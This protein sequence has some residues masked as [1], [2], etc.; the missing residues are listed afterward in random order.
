MPSFYIY[1]IS[2]LPMLH[3]GIKPPF[4]LARFI[5][6]CKDKIPDADIEVIKLIAEDNVYKGPQATLKQWA[7]FDIAL[8]NELVKIRASR[9][10]LD[11]LKYIRGEEYTEPYI[12]HLA[13]NAYRA[14]SILEAEKILDE[15]RWQRLEELATGHYFDLDFL[16]VYAFKLLLLERWQ[17]VNSADKP[18]L[19]EETLN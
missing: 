5:E 18:K 8:K 11:P 7:A 12:A 10:H 9:K 19:L 17:R 14:S 1:L 16:I 4:S 13:I 2:S 3:F 6:I 15:A